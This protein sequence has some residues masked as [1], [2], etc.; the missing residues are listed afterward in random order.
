[1]NE[2]IKKCNERLP[3]VKEGGCTYNFCCLDCE[4]QVE[5]MID[6]L[7]DEA[8]KLEPNDPL[9]QRA[10]NLAQTIHDAWKW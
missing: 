3:S 8:E 4:E 5:D 1:M 7:R 9:R 6:N 10:L 2:L